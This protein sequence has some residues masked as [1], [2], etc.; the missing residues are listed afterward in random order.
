ME[1]RKPGRRVVSEPFF[2]ASKHDR[3]AQ[4][5][6]RGYLQPESGDAVN[7]AVVNIC[8][9]PPRLTPKRL[10]DEYAKWK[11]FQEGMPSEVPTTDS[12][13]N[14]EHDHGGAG[15]ET[16]ANAGEKRKRYASSV[17]VLVNFHSSSTNLLP[18][19]ILTVYGSMKP[20]SFCMSFSDSTASATL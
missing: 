5:F 2:D 18:R 11:P 4:V 12:L 8:S 14:D 13:E 19:T 15:I 6:E 1:N 16:P 7:C 9:R 10:V 20:L 17:C 3:A